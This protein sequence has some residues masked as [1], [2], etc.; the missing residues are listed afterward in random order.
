VSWLDPA[1]ER[2][3]Y[4]TLGPGESHL[5]QTFSGHV[6]L[7]EAPPSA[8]CMRRELRYAASSADGVASVHLDAECVRG[9]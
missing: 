2:R 4:A 7:L 6:W 1:G 3:Q 5:Q 8:E 9:A